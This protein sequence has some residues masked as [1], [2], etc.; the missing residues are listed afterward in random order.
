MRELQDCAN[1]KVSMAMKELDP[2]GW[3]NE[4]EEKNIGK[5]R[6]YKIYSLKYGIHQ[7]IVFLILGAHEHAKAVCTLN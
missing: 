1:Q 5:G 7:D 6:P 3:I 4:H 2:H